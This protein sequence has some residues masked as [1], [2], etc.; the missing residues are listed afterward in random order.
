MPLVTE[1]QSDTSVSGGKVAEVI[2][3]TASPI[4]GNRSLSIEDSGGV[5]GSPIAGGAVYPVTPTYSRGFVMGRL[6]TLIRV[7]DPGIHA[8]IYCMASQDIGIAGAGSAYVFGPVGAS[9]ELHLSRVSSGVSSV[10]L[11]DLVDL[12]VNLTTGVTKAIELEWKSDIGIFGGIQFKIRIGN[13]TDFSDLSLVSTYTHVD[14]PLTAS[15]AEGL[16]GANAGILSTSR[17][18]FDNTSVY[19]TTV[20]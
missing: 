15:A 6:R 5:S 9:N 7:D 16:Y 19:E 14:T 4:I 20:I 1:W 18:I 10:S 17:Y 3:Y 2:H 8:G 13:A 12:G 11:L